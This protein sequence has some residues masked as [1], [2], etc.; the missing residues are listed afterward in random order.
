MHRRCPRARP[1]VQWKVRESWMMVSDIYNSTMK[2]V[3]GAS[4]IYNS[5]MVEGVEGFQIYT[6]LFHDVGGALVKVG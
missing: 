6:L 1:W 2:L 5:T 3:E 4:D